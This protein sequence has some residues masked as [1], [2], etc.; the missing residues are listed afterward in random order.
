MN[1]KK[2]LGAKIKNLRKKSNFTQEKLSEIIDINPRQMVR[3]EMGQSFPTIEN[4][5][6]IAKA[7]NTSVKELFN[8][9]SF[10]DAKKLKEKI[11]EK[12]EKIDE[13]SLRF[14]Y[15]VAENLT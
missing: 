14:L 8:N 5:E 15:N 13:K 2:L 12:L 9:D 1:T 10:D 6:K 4:L 3:I 11:I 7:L